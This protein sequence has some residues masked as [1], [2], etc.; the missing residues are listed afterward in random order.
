MKNKS[1]TEKSRNRKTGEEFLKK[2]LNEKQQ[3]KVIKL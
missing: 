1:L 3:Q 2:L